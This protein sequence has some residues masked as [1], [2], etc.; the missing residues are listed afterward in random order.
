MDAVIADLLGNH[1][2]KQATDVVVSGCSAGGLATY[3]HADKVRLLHCC[4]RSHSCLHALCPC[5]PL[6]CSCV[7]LLCCWCVLQWAAH[8]PVDA[9]VIAMPDSG[10]FLDY[11]AT[12][13]SALGEQ[14]YPH[15]AVTRG[16]VAV[17]GKRR[18]ADGSGV[19]VWGG[20]GAGTTDRGSVE[21]F[22]SVPR[23]GVRACVRV[24]VRAA[25]CTTTAWCGCSSR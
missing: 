16:G 6:L 21:A 5:A 2:M 10:F 9:H 19:C 12:A 24:V 8:M 13:S 7:L 17:M 11:E 4:P 22:F 1:N 3:L 23:Y 18:G 25:Q 15:G 14:D 20:G